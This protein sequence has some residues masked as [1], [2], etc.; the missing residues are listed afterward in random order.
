MAQKNFPKTKSASDYAA[1]TLSDTANFP[2]GPC[3]SIWCGGAG[4]VQAVRWDDTVVPFT[5]VAGSV[6]PIAAKR[7]NN[8]STTATLLVALYV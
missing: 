3:D 1:I 8:T 5:V 7:V 2:K 4:I 6:L